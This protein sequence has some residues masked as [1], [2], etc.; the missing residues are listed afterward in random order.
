[1][2][3]VSSIDPLTSL[4]QDMPMPDSSGP[5][6]LLQMKSIFPEH[7]WALVEFPSGWRRLC[8]GHYSVD[9]DFLLL[10][11]DLSLNHVVCKPFDFGYI[12]AD[13]IREETHTL[14]GALVL[15][16]FY[17]RPRWYV[18][19]ISSLRSLKHVCQVG[20]DGFQRLNIKN[21]TQ[22]DC[23]GL[24]PGIL[25]HSHE[26][27]GN[28]LLTASIWQSLCQSVAHMDYFDLSL[29]PEVMDHFSEGEGEKPS[30]WACLP[31]MP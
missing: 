20:H 8:A 17:G 24:G 7:F 1:M 10:R 4:W 23:F 19:Q 27:L 2:I 31:R 28:W 5:L 18:D 13:C 6:R 26:T 11:G 22:R 21:L 9:E 29:I 12:A 15:A 3:T 30:C 25:A 16:R 14:N